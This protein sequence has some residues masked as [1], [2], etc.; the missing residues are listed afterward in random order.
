MDAYR[1]F[2]TAIAI[3]A[4]IVVAWL[5]W[6]TRRQAQEMLEARYAQSRP[7]VIPV[8]GP[9]LRGDGVR[10]EF[11][12][13]AGPDRPLFRNIG[14]GP[15]LNV[16]AVIFGPRPTVPSA[17]HPE[18][19][20][21]IQQVPVAAAGESYGYG[22]AGF[23]IIDGETTLD[24]RPDHTLYAPPEPAQGEVTGHAAV[25]ILAR[26]TITYHDIFGR[27]HMSIFDF[28]LRHH[29]RCVGFVAN[30]PKDLE[31]VNR[32]QYVARSTGGDRPGAVS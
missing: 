14:P 24:G 3:G 10:E 17:L 20:T 30:I 5:L 1:W 31:E 21:V 4:V 16:W 27:K 32:E 7:L 23:T 6:Q 12:P 15:A 8:D 28:D 13:Y 11:D 9:P 2:I 19:R 25:R 26:Y 18:R 22:A 29:W